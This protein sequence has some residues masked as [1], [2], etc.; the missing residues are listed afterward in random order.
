MV[1][2]GEGGYDDQFEGVPWC[3]RFCD[4]QSVLP[5]EVPFVP[6]ASIEHVELY[7]IAQGSGSARPD[8]V[9]D[10]MSAFGKRPAID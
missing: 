3:H 10:W 9:N 6:L 1:L 7:T 4:V 5:P 8:K 2:R